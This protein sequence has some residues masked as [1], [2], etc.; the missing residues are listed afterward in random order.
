LSTSGLKAS[1]LLEKNPSGKEEPSIFPSSFSAQSIVKSEETDNR[2][3]ESTES[4]G[5]LQSKREALPPG[6]MYDE[7]GDIIMV[8]GAQ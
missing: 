5:T 3:A 6:F 2:A 7:V 4:S 1:G 8:G